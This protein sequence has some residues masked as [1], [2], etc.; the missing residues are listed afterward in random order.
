MCSPALGLRLG[1]RSQAWLPSCGAGLTCSQ[2]PQSW[3]RVVS[4]CISMAAQC[5]SIQGPPLGNP[6]MISPQQTVRGPV[7]LWLVS[8]GYSRSIPEQPLC[9]TT[10]VCGVSS[11][12][13]S[14]SGYSE[15]P[16]A[17][18]CVVWGRAFPSILHQQQPIGSHPIPGTGFLGFCFVFVSNNPCFL[19]GVLFPNADNPLFKFLLLF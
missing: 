12:R 6:L 7:V 19:K 13:I 2:Y 10:E 14:P 8:R 18:A 16:V 9:P 5:C 15:Q 11:S 3:P 4:E 1:L 17:V